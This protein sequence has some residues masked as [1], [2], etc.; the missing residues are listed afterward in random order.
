M[1]SNAR[2]R[3]GVP[4]AA[5]AIPVQHNK[6]PTRLRLLPLGL[7]AGGI[8]PLH[9]GIH[10]ESGECL[11]LGP[12]FTPSATRFNHCKPK[13]CGCILAVTCVMLRELRL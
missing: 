12:A 8:S 3:L 9:Y 1:A 4:F 11:P 5:A 2:D 10:L 6:L 13:A 7:G